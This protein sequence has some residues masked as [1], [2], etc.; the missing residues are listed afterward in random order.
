MLWLTSLKTEATKDPDNKDVWIWRSPIQGHRYVLGADVARGDAKDSSTF[1]IIDVDACEVV[2]EYCG[3]R[4][5]DKFAELIDE[6]GRRYNNALVCPEINSFGYMTCSLLKTKKYPR[7]Y[8]MKAPKGRLEGYVPGAEEIPGFNTDLNTRR[9]ALSKLETAI[10]RRKLRSYSS[11]LMTEFDTFIWE[12]EKAR[13]M[14]G[15][16]DDLIVSLAISIY[17]ME[18]VYGEG[19]GDFVGDAI[20]LSHISKASRPL[21]EYDGSQPDLPESKNNERRSP[22]LTSGYKR[23]N[24][25]PPGMIDFNWLIK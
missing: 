1:H 6:W 19:S 20:L 3:K 17:V 12:G 16:H 7:L 2:V 23:V 8:Y 14:R 10:R 22:I 25:P 9:I 11:R 18:A 4:P 5:P 13:P 21:K 24:A 15:K